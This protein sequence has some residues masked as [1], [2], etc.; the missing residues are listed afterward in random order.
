[1]YI[2]LSKTDEILARLKK[3]GKIHELNSPEDIKKIRKMNDYMKDVHHDYLY[4]AAMSEI[5]AGKV[6]LNS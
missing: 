1:M 5:S 2:K 4:K 6:I 3:E